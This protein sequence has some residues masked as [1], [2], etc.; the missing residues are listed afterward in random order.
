M[1]IYV[2][3]LVTCIII[4]FLHSTGSERFIFDSANFLFFL[5]Y[6][7]SWVSYIYRGFYKFQLESQMKKS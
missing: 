3:Y 4:V 1:F 7:L 6:T 5:L 2:H